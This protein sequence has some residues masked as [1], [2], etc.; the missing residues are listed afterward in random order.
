MGK[1]FW[2][3][4][5]LGAGIL[6][7]WQMGSSQI[8]SLPMT[9]IW[10]ALGTGE[11]AVWFRSGILCVCVIKNFTHNCLFSVPSG[12]EMLHTSTC[13]AFSKK[14]CLLFLCPLACPLFSRLGMK[15]AL[16]YDY[17][18]NFHNWPSG[19]FF[20]DMTIWCRMEWL[21]SSL[22][23]TPP[24]WQ[25]GSSRTD[26][27]LTKEK[28]ENKLGLRPL[29][30]RS[31]LCQDAAVVLLPKTWQVLFLP[32]MISHFS[33]SLGYQVCMATVWLASRGKGFPYIH[34]EM[35]F[36]EERRANQEDLLGTL[37]LLPFLI[38]RS[39]LALVF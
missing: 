24:L 1:S 14:C 37:D 7:E 6:W 13:L 19:Q 17:K 33:C 36:S 34:W 31:A 2:E 30:P 3:T 20:A 4:S 27:K 21:S 15:G 12:T 39:C 25:V 26:I 18:S 11:T 32:L 22:K 16:Q 5:I 28:L 23:Q 35:C 10:A 29:V 38:T 9:H 8:L